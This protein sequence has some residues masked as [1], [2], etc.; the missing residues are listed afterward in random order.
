MRHSRCLVVP[1]C[2]LGLSSTR[3]QY[4]QWE[5]DVSSRVDCG[6]AARVQLSAR[7]RVDRPLKRVRRCA[8]CGP[9]MLTPARNGSQTHARPYVLQ[10][11]LPVTYAI[12]FLVLI[13]SIV[14]P[15]PVVLVAT[16]LA[17]ATIYRYKAFVFLTL[18]TILLLGLGQLLYDDNRG[19]VD[20]LNDQDQ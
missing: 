5:I 19:L 9:N 10:V 3:V 14:V 17:V 20:L 16:N 6:H 2:A 1:V 4:Q 7:D 11:K 13:V 18:R 15:Q 8:I 12:S